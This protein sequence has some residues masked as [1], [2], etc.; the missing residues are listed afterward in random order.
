MLLSFQMVS[1]ETPAEH[2]AE[3]LTPS[4]FGDE[5]VIV[6][7]HYKQVMS[8]HDVQCSICTFIIQATACLWIKLVLYFAYIIYYLFLP[9]SLPLGHIR[10]SAYDDLA[11]L[12]VW[13]SALY[14]ERYIIINEHLTLQGVIVAVDLIWNKYSLTQ[15][16]PCVIYITQG[17]QYCKL[18]INSSVTH[19]SGNWCGTG[20]SRQTQ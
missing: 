1:N 13:I 12:E 15:G 14:C 17:T 6:P 10:H 2:K 4:H 20:I 19:P 16:V 11:H 8:V 3:Q 18:S 5:G 7:C 9:H